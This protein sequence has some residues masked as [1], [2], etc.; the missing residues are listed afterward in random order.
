MS[1]LWLGYIL[2]LF[3][4]VCVELASMLY[5]LWDVGGYWWVYSRSD[6]TPLQC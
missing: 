1:T 4:E 5:R 6:W 3:R 2:G